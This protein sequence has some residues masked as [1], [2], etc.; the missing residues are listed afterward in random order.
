MK[1][2]KSNIQKVKDTNKLGQITNEKLT[3]LS[4]EYNVGKRDQI[5]NEVF[6]IE[7]PQITPEE[8]ALRYNKQI[9]Q[10]GKLP[11]CFTVMDESSELPEVVMFDKKLKL[12]GRLR[13]D[14]KEG[15]KR[16]STIYRRYDGKELMKLI[17]NNEL[18][19]MTFM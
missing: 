3:E 10:K 17:E 1:R 11:K 8:M 16:E 13:D 6:N 14:T 19:V 9:L 7:E 18:F 5:F 15:N 4:N 12:Y 2:K